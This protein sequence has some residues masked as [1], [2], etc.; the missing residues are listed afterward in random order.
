[1]KM[2]NIRSLL[3]TDLVTEPTRQVLTERLNAPVREPTF[4][5]VEEFI[6]LQAICHRLT[7]QDGRPE[8]ERVDVAGCIDQRLTE[9]KS[10]GWRYDE[11]PPDPEAY[12]MGLC[13]IDESARLLFDK[14]FLGLS[15]EQQDA[16]LKAVQTMEVSGKTWQTLPADRFFEELLAE[17]VEIYYSHPLAQE[18][19]NYVGFTDAPGWQRVGLNNLEEREQ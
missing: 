6:L 16:L 19:I 13:G 1:M 2:M 8:P 4:F 14:P 10:N 11:M 18:E 12:R 3:Q 17:A 5:S 9:N 7:P 15:G